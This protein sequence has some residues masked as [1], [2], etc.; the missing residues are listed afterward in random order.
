MAVIQR[1]HSCSEDHVCNKCLESV[2]E[3]INRKTSHVTKIQ[4]CTWV[5]HKFPCLQTLSGSCRTPNWLKTFPF[6]GVWYCASFVLLNSERRISSK[7]GVFTITLWVFHAITVMKNK[8]NS[9]RLY[10]FEL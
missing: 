9:I 5:G 3:T 6:L 7:I 1:R 10:N 2:K 8:Y 4:N